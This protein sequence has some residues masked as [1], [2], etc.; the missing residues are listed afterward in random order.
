[1]TW[2]RFSYNCL[3]G[4]RVNGCGTLLD[5]SS[6]HSSKTSKINVKRLLKY[7]NLWYVRDYLIYSGYWL[8]KKMVNIFYSNQVNISLLILLVNST[9][10][11][12]KETMLHNYL[13]TPDTILGKSRAI[14][15][16]Q[17]PFNAAKRVQIIRNSENEKKTIIR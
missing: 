4:V 14:L 15:T 5:V 1:M 17:L 12:S 6:L 13:H 7:V 10:I 3:C 8:Q 11:I 2:T 16:L 9:I